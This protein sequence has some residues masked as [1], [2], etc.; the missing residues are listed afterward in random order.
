LNAPTLANMTY[1]TTIGITLMKPLGLYLHLPF[2]IHKCAYCD[3]VSYSG[4]Q[5]NI[6]RYV[7]AVARELLWYR[8][9]G[10]FDEYEINT[11]YVGGGT[12][13]LAVQS[14][15]LFFEQFRETLFANAEEMTV[16][17][18]PGTIG[19]AGLR[20]LYQAGCRRLSIGVQSFH[21]HE[22][23]AL[24]RI[25]SVREA[26]LCIE[27]ART[28]GFVNL[29]L[30]VMFGIPGS[31][32]ASWEETIQRTLAFLPEHVSA[33]NLTIEEGTLFWQQQQSGELLLPDDDT[34]VSMYDMAIKMLTAAGYDHYEISNFARP[35]HRSQHNQM[36][37]RNE[38]YLGLGAAAYSY[39]NGCRY[40]NEAS[41][42]GYLSAVNSTGD[43]H[44]DKEMHP[45]AVAGQE[46]LNVEATMGE[47]LMMCL[48]LCEGVK[49]AWFQQRFGQALD[50]MYAPQI[51]RLTADGLLE[52]TSTYL[53]LTHRGLLFANDVLQEFLANP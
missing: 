35:G 38:E 49:L 10:L 2:C 42:D 12:P 13:S 47:T 36:Y 3:F 41:L 9:R 43:T 6:P 37:W 30:D 34:Q 48:R 18:N 25:H 16:E 15:A 29:S 23:R 45:P 50:R 19:L 14:L 44:A 31:T 24:G 28:A 1:F 11:I 8:D 51:A 20:L 7:E 26:E 22:L 17:V 52:A 53:R 32:P 4:R 21:E 33:Y 39:L 5:A 27:A 40:W 46:I